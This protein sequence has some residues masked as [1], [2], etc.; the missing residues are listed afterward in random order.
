M[1]HLAYML[2]AAATLTAC[3]KDDDPVVP[4]TPPENEEEL[5]TTVKLHFHSAGGT[6]H[7]QFTWMDEDGISGPMAA[8][9]MADSL[10]ADTLYHVT[11]EVRNDSESPGED[12]TQEIE[13]ES[14]AHQFF[15][16]VSG[17]NASVAYAD[18]DANNLPIGL[19]TMWT[20]GAASTGTVLVTLRHE[21][22]KTAAGVSGGDITNAGGETDVEVT[23][24]LVID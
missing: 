4:T 11:I 16:Q 17:A 6:E 9:I 24:P 1:K 7:K 13:D 20:I 18:M 15:F 21:P 22:D 19:E 2:I 12:V 3:K 14:D 5:I 10:S 23:F 8:Q